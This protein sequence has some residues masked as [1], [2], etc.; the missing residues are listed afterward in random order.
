VRLIACWTPNQDPGMEIP[1]SLKWGDDSPATLEDFIRHQLD[2][3]TFVTGRFG[4]REQHIFPDVVAEVIFDRLA[5]DWV[6]RGPGVVTAALELHNPE[7]TDDEIAAELFTFSTV[8]RAQI[9]RTTARIELME[10]T[11]GQ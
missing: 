4:E 10:R 3:H 6:V 5:D 11:V 9:V 2:T 8:Y 7:A 1:T